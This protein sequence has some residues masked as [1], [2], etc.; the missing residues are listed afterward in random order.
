MLTLTTAVYISLYRCLLLTSTSPAGSAAVCSRTAAGSRWPGR[1]GPPS[2][3]PP[4]PSG[5]Q[6]AL[7]AA[8]TAPRHAGGGGGG[9]GGWKTGLM[10][11]CLSVLS[12]LPVP[13]LFLWQPQA[14]ESPPLQSISVP[15]FIRCFE[16]CSCISHTHFLR[17][18]ADCRHS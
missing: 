4:A 5:P 18:T 3:Q 17:G 9:G 10:S 11:A 8:T 13:L 1:T 6:L 7:A 12:S 14:I 15:V 2:A 16:L